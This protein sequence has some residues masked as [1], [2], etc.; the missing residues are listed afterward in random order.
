MTKNDS[1]IAGNILW[2][3]KQQERKQKRRVSNEM[4]KANKE[5]AI[6]K[7]STYT[8]KIKI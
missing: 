7:G 8:Q 6:E 4:V 5:K 1:Q 3:D 2:K